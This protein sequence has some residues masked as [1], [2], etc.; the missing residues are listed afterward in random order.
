MHELSLAEAMIEQ[1]ERIV[2]EQGGGLV[3][4]IHLEIGAMSGVDRDSFEF[5]FPVASRNS[6]AEGARLVFDE[7]K[8]EFLCKSCRKVTVTD[9]S[10]VMCG[11]CNGID[12]DIRKGRHFRITSLEVQEMN[13]VKDV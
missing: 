4:E 9:E 8:L 13:E 10:V 11:D 1:V 12:V 6:I 7:V 3:E 5:V 2:A